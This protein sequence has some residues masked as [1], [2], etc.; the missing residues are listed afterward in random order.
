[1]TDATARFR[2]LVEMMDEYLRTMPPPERDRMMQRHLA[3]AK[4]PSQRFRTLCDGMNRMIEAWSPALRDRMFA[5][6]AQ[7]IDKG[8]NVSDEEMIATLGFDP[9]RVDELEPPWRNPRV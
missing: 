3:E 8:R 5:I 2:Q 4:T 1:M 7:A 9:T 6:Y